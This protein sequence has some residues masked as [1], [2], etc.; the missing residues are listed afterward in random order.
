MHLFGQKS[1]SQFFLS[2]KGPLGW[3]LGMKNSE[4]SSYLGHLTRYWSDN[5]NLGL[6]LKSKVK[7]F[8]KQV[9]A[10]GWGGGSNTDNANIS[11]Q[12]FLHRK[13]PTLVCI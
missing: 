9:L 7:K 5:V 12:Q 1:M 3:G 13:G 6:K 4:L 10:Y 8:Y 11:P 2:Q